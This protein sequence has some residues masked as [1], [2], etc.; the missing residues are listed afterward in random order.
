MHE[1]SLNEIMTKQVVTVNVADRFSVVEK[2][3][4]ENKIRHLPVVDN[5]N[6]VV[7]LVSQ[8]DLYRISPPRKTLEGDGYDAE[9][10][11]G[12]ILSN[13]MT[14]LVQTLGEQTALK[15]AVYLMADKKLGCIPVVDTDAR[16]CGIL[17]KTDVLKFLSR[18]FRGAEERKS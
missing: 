9:Y 3:L 6:R 7:G 11:D 18:S 4:R 17:T 10:L 15:E 2:R 1:I 14:P 13:V 5:K 8:R 16:L 12:F